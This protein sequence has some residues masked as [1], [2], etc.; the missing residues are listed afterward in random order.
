MKGVP[1]GKCKKT[2]PRPESL[3]NSKNSR[4]EIKE[5]KETANAK[6]GKEKGSRQT[7]EKIKQNIGKP[8]I[9]AQRRKSKLNGLTMGGPSALRHAPRRITSSY[10]WEEPCFAPKQ[11][12]FAPKH[13]ES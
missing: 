6:K 9:K 13:W 10:A 3:P 12:C 1:G 5:F 4:V 11:P 2:S 7:G 8:V